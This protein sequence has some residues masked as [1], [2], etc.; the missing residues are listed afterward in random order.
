MFNLTVPSL[1]TFAFIT[2]KV[3]LLFTPDLFPFRA[4]AKEACP[5]FILPLAPSG[6]RTELLPNT[7]PV[8]ML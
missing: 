4:I 6:V 3:P 7:L 1:S 5:L 8:L 2:A